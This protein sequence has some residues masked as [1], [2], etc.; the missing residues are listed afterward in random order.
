[1]LLQQQFIMME[2]EEE[3][4]AVVRE[5]NSLEA[6]K[7]KAG[8][9]DPSG[10]RKGKENSK[11]NT[12]QAPCCLTQDARHT[13]FTTGHWCLQSAL[14]TVSIHTHRTG[15][16]EENSNLQ[17]LKQSKEGWAPERRS[18]STTPPSNPIQSFEKP[19]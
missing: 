8:D 7:G 13:H 19:I 3:E 9:A 4:V 16:T 18:N 10:G 2:V 14:H 12:S 1:M 15:S 5:G 17:Q 6:H 11:G